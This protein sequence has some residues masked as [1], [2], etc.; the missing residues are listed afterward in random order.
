MNESYVEKVA[1]LR[2]DP[3]EITGASPTEI[4]TIKAALNLYRTRNAAKHTT[5]PD[6]GW[7][8]AADSAE[9]LEIRISD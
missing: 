2:E 6:M 8:T 5:Q 1:R 7:G 3:I 4:K 9:E